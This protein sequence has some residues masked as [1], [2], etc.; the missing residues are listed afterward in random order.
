MS[1]KEWYIFIYSFPMWYSHYLFGSW[2]LQMFNTK[3]TFC[4]MCILHLNVDVSEVAEL[5]VWTCSCTEPHE[6]GAAWEPTSFIF[7]F[8]FLY[9]WVEVI[10]KEWSYYNLL[11]MI[12]ELL[13]LVMTW[14][15]VHGETLPHQSPTNNQWHIK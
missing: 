5:V 11:N 8:L 13:T 10:M 12:Q 4:M 2:G 14:R 1:K 6:S 7:A 15:P 3:E 9:K